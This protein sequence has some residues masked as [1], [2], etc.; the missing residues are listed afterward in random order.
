VKKSLILLL[1]V[2][3][4][5]SIVL[6]A[7]SNGNKD[8]SSEANQKQT[9]NSGGD[10]QSNPSSGNGTAVN[11]AG[12]FPIVDEEITLTVLVRNNDRV[13]DW[14]N[15]YTTQ[16][17]KEKTNVNLKFEVASNTGAEQI[18]NLALASGDY[19]DIIMGMPITQS[20]LMNYGSQGIFLPL[21]DIIQTYGDNIL[22]AFNEVPYLE[23]LIT[24]PDGNIYSLPDVN[25]CYHCT[26]NRKMFVYQPWLDAVGMKAPTT[27]DEFY[28]MLKAFKTQ[29]PNKNN[30]AD[31][32][33]L[34]GRMSQYFDAF[35][36]NAFIYHDGDKRLRI[37]DGQIDAIY[38]EPEY[39]EGMRYFKKLYDEGLIA[40]ETFTQDEGGVRAMAGNPDIP[41]LGS[42]VAHSP[43]SFIELDLEGTGRML[44]YVPLSP[45]KGPN[46]LQVAS[47]LPW[48]AD[49]GKFV[50]TNKNKHP[51]ASVRVV[52]LLYSQEGTMIANHGKEG[53]EWG[54][55]TDGMIGINNKPALYWTD[56][57]GDTQTNEHYAQRAPTYRSKDFRGLESVP[58]GQ[59]TAAKLYEDYTATYYE[60][61][62]EDLDKI[63]PP[64]FFTEQQAEELLPIDV[65]LNEYVKSSFAR[66]VAGQLDIDKDWDTYVATLQSM[67]LDKYLSI[68]NEAYGN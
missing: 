6:A 57:L 32:I 55:A 44:D 37:V 36:M 45:V 8:G 48:G 67:G 41:I 24:A 42:V 50:I 11:P 58:E 13:L 14:E 38:D 33:P 31:E 68:Y 66:F 65:A 12:A 40:P 53:G 18:L 4:M 60:A 16:W 26:M 29:D 61:Y 46:G 62:K 51:E 30:L 1:A 9:S 10:K 49:V 27:T 28:D 3:M 2:A 63:V 5:L 64:L 35:L 56:Y 52:D 34:S 7:C 47:Y 23:D 15:N 17:I 59:L 19:P 39:Q 25:E 43:T 20:M 54:W 21:Q 22:T